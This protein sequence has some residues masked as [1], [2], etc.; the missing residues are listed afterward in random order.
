MPATVRFEI[1][2]ADL[3]VTANFYTHVLGFTV[4]QDRRDSHDPYM[5]L[6]RDAVRLGAALGRATAPFEQRRP[7]MGVELVLEVD[8]LMAER[9]H[10]SEAGW[11]V[12][13]DVTERPWGLRD[14]R[15]IDP[16][17]YYWRITNRGD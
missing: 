14:F 16:D 13:E 12:D 6:T 9:R 7:P 3:N 8:D 1:F 17:G 4:A 2:P 15:L 5:Y 11:S 10:V